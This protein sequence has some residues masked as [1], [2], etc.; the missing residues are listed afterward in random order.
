MR[1]HQLLRLVARAEL[2]GVAKMLTFGGRVVQ[3]SVVLVLYCALS[4]AQEVPNAPR[5]FQGSYQY[6]PAR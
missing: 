4:Q 6:Q 5:R 2:Q 1:L 3:F